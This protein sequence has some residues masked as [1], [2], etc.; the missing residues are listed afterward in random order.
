MNKETPNPLTELVPND[1]RMIAVP[2]TVRC[3][4]T[5]VRSARRNPA[6]MDARGVFPTRSSSRIRSKI[7]MFV[8]TAMP[9]VSAM[10]ARP[11]KV[12]VARMAAMQAK[13]IRRFRP[14]ATPARGPRRRVDGAVED[15]RQ[16][17]ADV[18]LGDLAEDPRT[19]RRELDR[20]L[21]VAHRVRVGRYLGARQLGA[22]QQG[23]LL[24]HVRDL[25]LG[26]RLLVDLAPVEDLGGLRKVT[27]Q[28]LIDRRPL[29]E[30]L[31]LEQRGLADEGLGARRVLDARQLDQDLIR[32]LARDRGLAHTELI[33]AVADGLEPLTDGVVAQLAGAPLAHH[34]PE[35]SGRLIV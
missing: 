26:L 28:R 6:S 31:E 10:P 9:I 23:A 21:P 1:R 18:L 19:G 7:R 35:G 30:Q 29:V 15:D 16:P 34:E 22:R 8:S 4:S 11:G 12:K 14:R 33:D 5:I 32:A 24:D 13:R 17:P 27:G 25:A 3:V 2:M 20:D